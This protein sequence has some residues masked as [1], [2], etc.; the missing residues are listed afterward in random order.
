M[1][2]LLTAVKTLRSKEGPRDVVS[3]LDQLTVST[4]PPAKNREITSSTSCIEALKT[5]PTYRDLFCILKFLDP[6]TPRVDDT[7]LSICISENHA[8][9][10]THLLTSVIIPNYWGVLQEQP[11]TDFDGHGIYNLK[12]ALLRCLSTVTGVISLVSRLRS[13]LSTE[14]STEYPA[15]HEPQILDT[16]SVLA[17]IL[18]PKDFL[19]NIYEAVNLS[20]PATDTQRRIQWQEF[21]AYIAGSKLLS[22]TAQAAHGTKALA[23]STSWVTN[24]EAYSSWLGSSIARLAASSITCDGNL[25][26]PFVEFLGRSL[27]L[28]YNVHAL[29]SKSLI[30][31]GDPLLMKHTSLQQQS[32]IAEVILLCA[33]RIRREKATDL[34]QILK[35]PLYLNAVSNRLAASSP[36]ARSL[37]MLLGMVLSN[38]VDTPGVALKF[39]LDQSEREEYVH[40]EK[41]TQL[42][43]ATSEADYRHLDIFLQ[44]HT[45]IK[46]DTTLDFQKTKGH[47]GVSSLQT[48]SSLKEELG[49]R[50]EEDKEF[51]PYEKP[52][53]DP[54]DSDDDVTVVDRPKVRP[55]IYIRDLL[56]YLRDS[57]D[58]L[59]YHSGITSA[60]ALIRKKASF[61]TEVAEYIDA[62]ALTLVSLQNKYDLPD[63]HEHRLRGQVS[64][65]VFFPRTMGKWYVNTLFNGD[66]SQDQR[67]SILIALGLSARELA[68][69]GEGVKGFKEP[70]TS[71]T[72]FPSKR[73]PGNMESIYTSGDRTMNAL[74]QDVTDTILQPIA[75][76]A[77]DS[78]TGPKALKT[79]VFSSRL[80]FQRDISWQITEFF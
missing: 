19:T 59:K 78:F 54:E 2:G 52:D 72:S 69:L 73:L 75:E 60:S 26:G 45:P 38:I 24:G 76:E 57:D 39:D 68:G 9:Q 55:P 6:V 30:S 37:G 67:S 74:A 36:R 20:T 16:L 34:H 42:E 33:G 1:D 80:D 79:R 27:K 29:M 48:I 64:M 31:F 21:T 62:L 49:S 17:H 46:P 43:D 51:L 3:S 15:R 44:N 50:G 7:N 70:E 56:N 8:S 41:L 63:F 4:S 61:G 22:T 65:L 77:V 53:S 18:K 35:S 71:T 40:L 25:P 11:C 14:T 47:Q 32:A 58:A 12:A 23:K 10:I 28:G 5:N 66:L 13:L